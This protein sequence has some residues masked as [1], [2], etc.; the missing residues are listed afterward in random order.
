MQHRLPTDWL[1]QPPLLALSGIGSA[2]R[3]LGTSPTP[4]PDT[5]DK[6]QRLGRQFENQVAATVNADPNLDLVARNLQIFDNGRTLGELD[7]LV[8]DNT[9]NVLMHWE[10]TVKFYLGIRPD[11]WPGPNPADSLA[12]RGNRLLEHQFPMLRN[13]L[14]QQLLDEHGWRVEEQ[15]LLSRGRLFYPAGHNWP[16]PAYSHPQH[17]RGQ[18]WHQRQLIEHR[19]RWQPLNKSEWLPAAQMSDNCDDWLA[20]DQMIDYVEA[21]GRP[22]MA[23]RHIPAAKP[24]PDFIVPQ[25]WLDDAR[26]ATLSA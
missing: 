20:S 22:V 16:A 1:G 12:Q 3:F 9:R 19:H 4:A 23:L 24:Q 14:C 11:H 2:D 15:Y 5:P 6:D 25:R 10:I 17:L 21:A 13:R 7:M 26:S 8:R 18:W